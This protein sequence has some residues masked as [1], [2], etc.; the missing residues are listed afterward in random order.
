MNI[1]KTK[2]EAISQRIRE[3]LPYMRKVDIGTIF[4][5]RVHG[6]IKC[7]YF[8][9]SED[10]FF[11][12]WIRQSDGELLGSVYSTYLEMV[13]K[14]PMLN[15]VLNY[16]KYVGG[17]GIDSPIHLNILHNWKLENAYLKDQEEEIIEYLFNLI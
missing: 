14:E 7:V 5:H 1:T 9:E 11:I 8:K 17:Y 13:G 6:D 10:E 12:K 2:V 3:D 15:D 16:F 4:N